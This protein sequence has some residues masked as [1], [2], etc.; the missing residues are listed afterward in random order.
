MKKIG[1]GNQCLLALVL[2]FYFGHYAPLEIVH[3]ITPLGDA[4]LQLLKLII[5]P[6]T[7]STIVASFSKVR[8]L[9]LVRKLG[10][11]T[12]FWFIV[13]ALIAATVGVV[14]GKV[15][16]PGAGLSLDASLVAQYKPR[17]IP[18]LSHTLLNMIPG[19]IIADIAAGR[20]IPVI[21]FAIF[22]GIALT[23][24][25]EKGQVV[26]EFFH[27]FSL[28]MFKITRVII[29]LSPIGIF[30][31]IAGV[32]SQYGVET[33]IPLAKFIGAVYLACIIQLLVYG[34]LLLV[35]AKTN[36]LKF[37]KA[38]YPAMVTAF[39]TSSS[40]GTLPVTLET[41]VDRVK[42]RESIATFVAPLGATMKMDGCGAIY[43]ALVCV[44]TANLLHIDLNVQQYIL[45]ILT[46][47]IATIG[48]AGVP[49]TA[50]IMATV[51]LTSVG[52]PLQGLALVIGIDKIIDMMRTMTN[53]T[54]GGVCSILV[55]NSLKK[56]TF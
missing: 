19:N 23:S 37:I 51:V 22:F 45:I 29:R 21:I 8:N 40:L 17:E 20:V 33:L 54:G 43:P 52:L 10:L 39:T 56:N 9:N 35:F 6:V 31:L 55:D 50:S 28:V 49:G 15:I 34:V 16:N 7:F 46:A 27:E 18:S 13:T 38:F 24:L 47:A 26:R 5:V 3:F 30:A 4:F 32:G 2:G 48:T 44:L 11:R 41:L 42:V 14:V 53:V 25:G 36:P 12:L 1:F